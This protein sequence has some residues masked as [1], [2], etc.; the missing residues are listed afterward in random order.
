MVQF[1]PD[2]AGERFGRF[3]LVLCENGA[4]G[5]HFLPAAIEAARDAA[6]GDFRRFGA[7]GDAVDAGVGCRFDQRGDDDALNPPYKF[8]ELFGV[9]QV[10]VIFLQQFARDGDPGEPAVERGLDVGE[11]FT[12]KGY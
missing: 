1:F 10:D 9:P 11:E 6:D 2:M 4:S 3:R 8:D 5:G 12:F 7:Q